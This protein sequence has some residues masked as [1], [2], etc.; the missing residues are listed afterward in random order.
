MDADTESPLNASTPAEYLANTTYLAVDPDTIIKRSRMLK[1]YE[2]DAPAYFTSLIPGAHLVMENLPHR[3]G[4]TLGGTTA[5][6]RAEVDATGRVRAVITEDGGKEVAFRPTVEYDVG[7]L[8]GVAIWVSDPTIFQGWISRPMRAM[9]VLDDPV[10][11]A[12]EDT[13]EYADDN[14]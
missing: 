11:D 5:F 8:G 1:L 10:D 4:Y 3:A 7:P 13:D 14:Q 2:E 12:D 6:K 9:L